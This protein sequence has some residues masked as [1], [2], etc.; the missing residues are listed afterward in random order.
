MKNTVIAIDGPAASGKSTTAKLIAEELN[1]LYIDTGAMYRAATFICLSNNLDINN[2]DLIISAL[3]SNDI[4]QQRING[5]TK[6]F[7]DD[8]DVSEEIRTREV[9]SNVSKIAAYPL[10]RD[11]LVNKQKQMGNSKNVIL[12]GRDIGTVVFPNADLKIFMVATVEERAKRRFEEFKSKG[13]SLTIEDVIDDIKKRDLLDE[14]REASP[15]RKA[16]DAIEI[17]TSELT[18]NEQ[19]EH[20]VNLVKSLN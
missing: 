19:V 16:D 14:Q 17:D 5:D 15:L 8:R 3:E 12:D 4:T 18:I 11:V 6:T 10:V 20:I 7:I 9:T 1:L 2:E 13:E